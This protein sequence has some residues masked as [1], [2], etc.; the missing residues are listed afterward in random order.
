MSFM[1]KIIIDLMENRKD[2]YKRR[3]L[4]VRMILLINI[5]L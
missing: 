3:R 1:E 2:L 5:V 4:F